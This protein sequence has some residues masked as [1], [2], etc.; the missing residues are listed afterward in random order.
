MGLLFPGA[1]KY[2][3]RHKNRIADVD[4]LMGHKLSGRD[5]FLTNEKAI[6]ARR[7]EL[8]RRFGIAVMS[9]DEFVNSEPD[10]GWA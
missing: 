4:H 2:K 3:A 9:P 6:F 10:A 1:D 7:A 5:V 8:L